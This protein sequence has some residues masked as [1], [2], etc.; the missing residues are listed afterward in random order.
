MK[1]EL[2]GQVTSKLYQVPFCDDV[3]K[4]EDGRICLQHSVYNVC[5]AC[6]PE[7]CVDFIDDGQQ[8]MQNLLTGDFHSNAI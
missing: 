8:I 2:C 1:C 3:E 7:E 4:D 6:V 5:S